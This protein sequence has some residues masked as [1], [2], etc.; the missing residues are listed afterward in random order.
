MRASCSRHQVINQPNTIHLAF[1]HYNLPSTKMKTSNHI[2]LYIAGVIVVGLALGVGYGYWQSNQHQAT[3]TTNTNVPTNT[4]TPSS[5]I[6]AEEPYVPPVTVKLPPLSESSISWNDPIKLAPLQLLKNSNPNNP[7]SIDPNSSEART[8]YYKVATINSPLYSDPTGQKPAEIILLSAYPEGP[9]LYPQFVRFIKQGDSLTLLGKSSVSP[10]WLN[11][12]TSKFNQDNTVEI[13]SLI[14][15]TT[16]TGPQ[17]RQVLTIDDFAYKLFDDSL[18]KTAFSDSRVGTVYTTDLA[19]V[20]AAQKPNEQGYINT[21]FFSG[22]GFYVK[23]P[24]GTARAYRLRLDFVDEQRIP[25]IT[26]TNGSKNNLIYTFTDVGGC[27]STNYQ[28]V[29]DDSIKRTDLVAIGVNSKK[30]SIYELKDK[31]HTLLKT[32]YQSYGDYPR[33]DSNGSPMPKLSYDDFLK[34]KPI[35]F[36][37]DPFNRL[38]KMFTEKYGPLTECGKP[39]IYLYP[40]KETVATVKLDLANGLSYS[41]PAYNSGWKVVAHPDGHLINTTDGQSYPYLFWEGKGGMYQAPTQGWVIKQ[42]EVHNFLIT[43]LTQQG[44]NENE[45]ADFLEFWEPRMQAKPYYF[46]SFLGTREMNRLA[47]LTIEPKPDTIIRVLMDFAALDKP[48]SVQPYHLPPKPERKGFTVVEW[49]GVI[50]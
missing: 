32:M 19:K 47:P 26:W 23:L 39:V 9:S 10:E 25:D 35:I 30:D 33:Y 8:E 15:P 42:S 41:N 44:L 29:V 14:A 21:N 16:I 36:W 7:T 20:K 11:F 45:I 24:D 48:I 13:K 2:S 1:C 27:G 5:E 46:I 3:P 4:N 28:A 37:I 49:G 43:S 17:P 38:T 31:N 50:Q 12:D 40:E 34:L 22:N 18:L 6:P